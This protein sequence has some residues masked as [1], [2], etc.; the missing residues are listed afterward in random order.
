MI[1]AQLLVPI[2]GMAL[3]EAALHYAIARVPVFPCVPG[4]KRPLLDHGFHEASADVEDVTRWWRRWPTANIGIPTGPA[5]GLEVVDVDVKGAEPRGPASWQRATRAGLLIGWAAHVVTPSGG[6]HAYHPAAEG[7]QRSWASG[8][9]QLDFRGSGGYVVAPP[10]RIVVDGRAAV[11][12]LLEV[13][14]EAAAPVDAA[15]LRDFLDPHP[16]RTFNPGRPFQ[17]TVQERAERLAKWLHRQSEGQ[18]NQGLFWASCRLIDEGVDYQDALQ[19][20]GPVAEEI[21]LPP[22]EIL[23]TIQSAY[24]TSEPA[25]TARPSV[26]RSSRPWSPRSGGP[27]HRGQAPA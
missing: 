11:Y 22:R 4:G 20:L 17:G 14:S 13:S 10:S 26:E 6:L 12:R 3:E 27:P 7:E 21:G 15:R 19:A 1:A 24:R 2:A 9:A 18:R 23:R 8:N 5:S 25:A 16:L